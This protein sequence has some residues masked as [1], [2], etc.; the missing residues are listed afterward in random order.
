MVVYSYYPLGE[1]R[2]QR[3]AEALVRAGYQVD[4]ICPR[5]AGEDTTETHGGVLI[6]RV[7]MPVLKSSLYVQMLGYILFF[8]LAGTILTARHLR[9]RYGTVQV[10][11][12]PDFLVFC[13]LI[14]KLTGASV[15]L[16]LH[17][18]MPEFLSS[19]FDGD[20][21]R[22]LVEAILLQERWSC[23]FADHVITV[24]EQWR[25]TL[26]Q[27]SGAADK[28]S[29]VMN[30]A[31]ERIFQSNEPRPEANATEMRLIYH[32]TVVY[33]YGLDL[34]VDAIARLSD[35]ASGITLRVV[36]QGDQFPGLGR[37]V[38][39]LGLEERV[40]L[41]EGLIPAEYLP[42]VIAACDVGVVPYRD[43]VFTDGLIPTKLLE[44]AAMGLP[45]VAAR[46]S[47]I[48]HLVGDSFVEYFQPGDVADLATQLA[49]LY[50]S[51]RRRAD[52]ADATA[53]FN[54][55]I[56]WSTL[57]DEYVDLIDT[58]SG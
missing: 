57:S 17:D 50:R 20:P 22:W 29:V 51:P 35:E 37:Q 18:L 15:I 44:Y 21:P 6:R 48:E 5:L 16:D 1:T 12:L 25:E 54:E 9:H 11:N 55:R 40:S 33:R 8:L 52:L 4:V 56:N 23:R 53:R 43:D 19:K 31:D 2:V 30:V 36:G 3:E 38:A 14:P 39:Q 26:A 10:H 46:T 27:R 13:A 41:E 42:E 47:A 7:P 32:G 28:S 58:L 49:G 34:V 24:S 45:V